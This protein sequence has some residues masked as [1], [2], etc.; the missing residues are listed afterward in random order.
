MTQSKTDRLPIKVRKSTVHGSGAFA[1][2]SLSAEDFVGRYAGK[3]YSPAEVTERDWDHALTF[4][5]GLSVGSVIDGAQGGNATR[6]INHSCSPN[7]AAFEIET[8]SGELRIVIEALRP[9]NAGEELFLDYRLDP[10]SDSQED[11]ACHCGT[12]RCR[13][14]LV[15]LAASERAL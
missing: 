13:G 12:S 8:E 11:F 5:F 2:R 1:A 6:H 9:I 10:G 14:T 3:L 7:C 15:S 4:V